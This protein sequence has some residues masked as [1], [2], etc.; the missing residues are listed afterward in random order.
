MIAA[1]FAWGSSTKSHGQNKYQAATFPLNQ[2]GNLK[3]LDLSGMRCIHHEDHDF[4]EGDGADGV[5]G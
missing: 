4:G 1:S 5:V 3:V 2:I